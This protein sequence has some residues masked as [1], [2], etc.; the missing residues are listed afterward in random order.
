MES[1]NKPII[2]VKYS[3]IKATAWLNEGE[4]GEFFSID[5]SRLFRDQSGHW[6]QSSNFGLADL[7]IV[8]KVAATVDFKKPLLKAPGPIIDDHI[9]L[10]NTGLPC[11]HVI[12]DF[13]NMSYWH[14]PG[15][16][17]DK[18]SP[19]MLEKVGKLTLGFLAEAQSPSSK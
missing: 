3:N 1:T 4:K 9:P 12:G 8:E 2:E 13:M 6:Q 16:T 5:V 14:Q 19:E 18:L 17:L 10:Q 11:L 15:D 7:P